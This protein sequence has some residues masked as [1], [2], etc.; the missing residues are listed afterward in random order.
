MPN[1]IGSQSSDCARS[2]ASLE[3]GFTNGRIYGAPRYFASVPSVTSPNLLKR[4]FTVDQPAAAWVIDVT[5]L[6]TWEGWLYLAVVM[7]LHRRR[8]LNRSSVA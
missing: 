2:L 3:V 7:D 6:R 8:L 1:G 5:Y 4:Q